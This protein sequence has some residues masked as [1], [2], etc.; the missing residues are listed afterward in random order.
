MFNVVEIQKILPHRY[1]FLLLDRVT[2]LEKGKYIE[3]Y[4]NV[5]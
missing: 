5:S 2:Q 4:K 3:G 1:P